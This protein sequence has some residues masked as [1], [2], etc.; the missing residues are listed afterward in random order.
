M[1]MFSSRERKLI[2]Y[3]SQRDSWVSSN[4]I[5]A[6]FGISLRTLRSEVKN[7]NMDYKYIISSNKGYKIIKNIKVVEELLKEKDSH[8]HINASNREQIILKELLLSKQP[9]DYF[10][11]SNE[12]F[13]SEQTLLSAITSLKKKISPYEVTIIRRKDTISLKGNEKNIRRLFCDTVYKEAENSILNIAVLNAFFV[14]IEVGEIKNTIHKMIYDLNFKINDFALNNIVLHICIIIDRNKYEIQNE[15]FEFEPNL[16]NSNPQYSCTSQMIHWISKKY[17]LVISKNDFDVIYAL[18]LIGMKET[19]VEYEN[20]SIDDFLDQSLVQFVKKIIIEVYNEFYINL[21]NEEFISNFSLHLNNII[22]RKM[23]LRNPLLTCIKDSYPTIYEISVFIAKKIQD[24]Y[25]FIDMNDH[26]ISYIALHVG[27]QIE[28]QVLTKI[29]TIVINPEYL[30][31][32]SLILNKLEANFLND[33]SIRILSDESELDKESIKNIDLILT[34]MPLNHYVECKVVNVSVF[35]SQK[36]IEN[37]FEAISEIKKNRDLENE[38]LLR[39]FDGSFHYFDGNVNNY[40]DVIRILCETH[41]ELDDDFMKR[42]MIREAI[43]PSEYLNIAVAHPIQCDEK[44][45]FISVGILKKPF[46]WRKNDI[47]IVFLLSVSQ[48]DK[49]NFLKILKQLIELFSSSRWMEQ[50]SYINTYEKFVRFIKE[51]TMYK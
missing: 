4:E 21:D 2:R 7:I 44:S 36:D 35:I 20:N 16:D 5:I 25:P 37:I 15:P 32:N 51:Y 33:L 42:V 12:L 47:N 38:Y 13:I 3:L 41:H 27:A 34:T 50:H 39:Y 14:D 26:Q 6:A 17:K 23:A 22:N 29:K 24:K 10:D 45:T 28:K 31:L 40:E 18:L 19:N 30:K 48:K 46:K 8:D 1:S 49:L 11:L 9:I 43:S